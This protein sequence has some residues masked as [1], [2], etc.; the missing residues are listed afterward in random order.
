M[1]DNHRP[2][3]RPWLNIDPRDGDEAR[4]WMARI[5]GPIEWDLRTG[6]ISGD[7]VIEMEAEDGAGERTVKVRTPFGAVHITGEFDDDGDLVGFPSRVYVPPLTRARRLVA[8]VFGRDRT[9]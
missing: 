1:M 6:T 7:L 3:A 8:K 4:P 5:T 9:R 2:D